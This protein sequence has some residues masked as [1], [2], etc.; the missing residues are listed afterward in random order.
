MTSILS[1]HP[2]P[3]RDETGFVTGPAELW[4][5]LLSVLNLKTFEVLGDIIGCPD[6]DDGG[7]ERI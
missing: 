5:Q 2:V 3:G 1:S 4:E 6:C 7:A